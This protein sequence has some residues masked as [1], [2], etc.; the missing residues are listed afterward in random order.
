M[1]N[2]SDIKDYCE[3]ELGSLERYKGY[4]YDVS[5]KIIVLLK[6][7]GILADEILSIK[8]KDLFNMDSSILEK[9]DDNELSLYLSKEINIKLQYYIGKISINT[10]VASTVNGYFIHI[11]K[12]DEVV[13]NIGGLHTRDEVNVALRVV[14]E[15]L[16]EMENIK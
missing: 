10:G 1:K 4:T 9:E 6:Y 13:H 7:I 12:D 3:K 5:G 14:N 8:N 16:I 2:L 15:L 11:L